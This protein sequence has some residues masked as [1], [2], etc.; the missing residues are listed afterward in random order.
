VTI[1]KPKPLSFP[2]LLVISLMTA[3]MTALMNLIVTVSALLLHQ[4]AD[5][6]KAPKLP[7]LSPPENMGNVS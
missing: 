2:L 4:H 6:S 3:L 5:T 1:A 7:F